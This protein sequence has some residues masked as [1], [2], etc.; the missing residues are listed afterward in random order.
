MAPEA[1]MDEWARSGPIAPEYHPSLE[2]STGIPTSDN[3]AMKMLRTPFARFRDRPGSPHP[4]DGTEVLDGD[5]GGL[6]LHH[7]GAGPRDSE[8]VVDLAKMNVR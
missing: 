2:M 5:G 3:G 8:T 7:V 6:R 4:S 1:V